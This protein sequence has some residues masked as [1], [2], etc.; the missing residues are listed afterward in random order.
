MA[1][2]DQKPAKGMMTCENCRLSAC[3]VCLDVLRS[4]YS[5]DRICDCSRHEHL[6]RLEEAIADL[7]QF[8]RPSMAIP[9]IP[10][11]RQ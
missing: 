2:H 8:S 7:Q 5:D 1:R 4:K 11:P 9:L 3:S 6:A 10:L